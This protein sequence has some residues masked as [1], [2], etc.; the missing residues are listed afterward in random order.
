MLIGLSGA[1]GTGK[2]T[3]A[4]TVAE[5]A[6]ARF[7]PTDVSEMARKAGFNPVAEM[8]IGERIDLQ[9]ALIGQ[10]EALVASQPS[11]M[12]VIMDRTPLDVAAYTLAEVTM[13]SWKDA[14]R[15]KWQEVCEIVTR[16]QRLASMFDA[17]AILSELPSYD[18]APKR[19]RYNPAYQI[20]I[21]ALIAGVAIAGHESAMVHFIRATDLE[22]RFEI[23]H[24]IIGSLY[25][26]E[27]QK[28]AR[29]SRL[30]C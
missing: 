27:P 2:T 26:I 6:G 12:C 13:Q 21:E 8:T 10:F 22:R 11:G 30:A 14:S 25:G 4:R 15:E 7:V 3:L 20:H 5:R 16:C 29:N 24:E 9:H 23:I 28:P 19:P 18:D 1:S 17:I